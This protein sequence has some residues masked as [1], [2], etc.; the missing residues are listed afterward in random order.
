MTSNRTHQESIS[1]RTTV[2]YISYRSE[3]NTVPVPVVHISVETIPWGEISVDPHIL[4]LKMS[5]TVSYGTIIEGGNLITDS[6]VKLV[7]IK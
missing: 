2:L 6:F 5:G 3:K 1:Q 4:V 7:I